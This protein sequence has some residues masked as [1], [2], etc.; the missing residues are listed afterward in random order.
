M[1]VFLGY[2]HEQRVVATV[3][4]IDR[5]FE[6]HGAVRIVLRKPEHPHAA[7]EASG[8]GHMIVVPDI[9]QGQIELHQ[10]RIELQFAAVRVRDPGVESPQISGRQGTPPERVVADPVDGLVPVEEIDR[11]MP[12]DPCAF[13]GRRS[14]PDDLP[15]TTPILRPL[16]DNPDTVTEFVDAVGDGWSRRGPVR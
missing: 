12:F 2:A 5:P 16:P 4:E 13:E 6:A 9:A 8:I 14:I 1:P 7:A 10:R 15:E 11:A 3:F